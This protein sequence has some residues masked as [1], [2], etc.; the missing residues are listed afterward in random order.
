MAFRRKASSGP[1][2]SPKLV[3]TEGNIIQLLMCTNLR[4]LRCFGICRPAT[5]RFRVL[6]GSWSLGD[7]G[8]PFW[9]HL[10]YLMYLVYLIPSP[11]CL[12]WGT[13]KQGHICSFFLSPSSAPT[14]CSPSL[15]SMWASL[16]PRFFLFLPPTLASGSDCP[17]ATL[18]PPSRWHLF[19]FKTFK[20]SSMHALSVSW[21]SPPFSCT[22]WW[23][24]TPC[25]P[26]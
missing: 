19:V 8:D 25:L 4:D 21:P 1:Q 6:G 23:T 15:L 22:P 3:H 20:L 26:M 12:Q 16:C 17:H 2:L 9:H 10:S 5:I 11:P 13:E 24:K 14:T 18:L 7:L